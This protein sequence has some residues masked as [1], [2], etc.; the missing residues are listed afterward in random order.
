[1]RR[2]HS[3]AQTSTSRFR[4]ARSRMPRRPP[5]AGCSTGPGPPTTRCAPQIA[6]GYPPAGDLVDARDHQHARSA[7]AAVRAA[8]RAGSPPARQARPLYQGTLAFMS[9]VATV[10]TLASRMPASAAPVRSCA[11]FRPNP[12]ARPATGDATAAR[13][14]RGRCIGIAQRAA[15]RRARPALGELRAPGGSEDGPGVAGFVR[16]QQSRAGIRPRLRL[17]IGQMSSRPT[18]SSEV[19][20]YRGPECSPLALNVRRDEC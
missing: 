5:H 15:R 12:S 6:S 13:A 20:T 19:S 16:K 17:L 7:G 3:S 10:R 14:T 18:P 8:A 9:P 4:R 2:S 1:M 11:C